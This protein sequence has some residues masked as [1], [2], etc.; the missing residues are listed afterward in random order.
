[1]N[2]IEVAEHSTGHLL[3]CGLVLPFHLVAIILHIEFIAGAQKASQEDN[4]RQGMGHK[5]CR[6]RCPKASTIRREQ[7][8][9]RGHQA[10][11]RSHISSDR[12]HHVQV[13]VCWHQQWIC[14]VWCNEQCCARSYL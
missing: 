7:P 8:Q 14:E 1:M 13:G 3:L 4:L 12:K 11:C 6:A 10:A 2:L 5:N 9:K